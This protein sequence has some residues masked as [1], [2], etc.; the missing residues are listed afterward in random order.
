MYSDVLMTSAY[1]NKIEVV[2]QDKDIPEGCAIVTV[3]DKCSAH[4]MLKGIIDPV[5][6]VEKLGKKQDLLKTQ[7]EKLK[8]SML[9]KDYEKKVPEDIRNANSEKV[10]QTETEI[11]RLDEAMAFLKAM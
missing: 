3:S 4:L 10:S 9:I 2:E 8:K 7:L 5:K 6:E 1:A 11:D